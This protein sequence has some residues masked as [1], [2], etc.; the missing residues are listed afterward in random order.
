M[1][2]R[3]AKKTEDNNRANSLWSSTYRGQLAL[4]VNNQ[5]ENGA[6]TCA[7]AAELGGGAE[8]K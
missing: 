4:L 2:K 8:A 7:N 3:S 5:I 1:V 6:A